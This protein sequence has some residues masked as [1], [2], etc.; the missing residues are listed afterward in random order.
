MAQQKLN[1]IKQGIGTTTDG[2]TWVALT[3]AVVTIPDGAVTRVS[4][5]VLGRNTATGAVA[6]AEGRQ[7]GKRVSGTLS[8]VG[9]LIDLV[10]MILGSDAAL[11]TSDYRITVSGTTLTLE[12]K[13]VAATTI[14]WQGELTCEIN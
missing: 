9:S 3:G 5:W 11:N 8:L 6:N 2:T 4:A 14:E 12:V 1:V 13:G 7:R 10:T